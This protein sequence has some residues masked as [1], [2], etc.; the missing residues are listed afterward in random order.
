[1]LITGGDLEELKKIAEEVDWGKR[2]ERLERWME[3]KKSE[4]KPEVGYAGD[5]ARNRIKVFPEGVQVMK[6]K[7]PVWDERDGMD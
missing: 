5:P 4:Q 2:R 6:T 7:A 1:M 3:A